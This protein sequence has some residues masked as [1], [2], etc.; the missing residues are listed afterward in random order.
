MKRVAAALTIKR[1]PG[2]DPVRIHLAGKQNQLSLDVGDL[3][4]PGPE[5]IVRSRRL[6]SSAAPSPLTHR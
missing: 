6:A 4:Q 3:A 2:V 5:Q 1:D